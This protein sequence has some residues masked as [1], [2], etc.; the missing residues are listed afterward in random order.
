MQKEEI[1]P[2]ISIQHVSKSFQNSKILD[3]VS[4][5]IEKGDIY[6]VLG[7]S[8]AGKSTLVRCINGLE[9]FDDGQIIFHDQILCNEKISVSKM[10]KRKIGMIFQ[11][12]NLLEQKD[13]LNN[14]MLGLE[15]AKDPKKKE[16][17]LQ[18]IEKVGLQ[19]KIHSFPAQLSGG[20][21][22]RV[23]IARVLALEPEVILSD[24]ATSALDPE[25]TSSVLTLLKE[26]NQKY[27]LTIVMI[28]HQIEAIEK[29]CNKVAILDHSKIIENGNTEDLFLKPKSDIT[30][31][32][33]YTAAIKEK[34]KIPGTIR[35]IFDGNTDE[36]V[37]AKIIKNCNI[38]I[39][40]IYADTKMIKNK[41]YG[42]TIIQVENLQQ[43]DQLKQYLQINNIK[44]E[45]G[46]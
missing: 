24:E 8:G 39:S 42:Q 4:L 35:L 5:D 28:S 15:I 32:L 29:I 33:V 37:L 38:V 2:L 3:D 46:K 43:L 26:L 7:L 14:V 40:I 13:V 30:K 22:Q 10:N 45:E 31:S 44:Y 1:M 16:K 9:T 23:A 34:L 6:G 18:A 12:F 25:T 21:K 11:G 41:L 19:D 17:A 36:P 27:G 20:Q